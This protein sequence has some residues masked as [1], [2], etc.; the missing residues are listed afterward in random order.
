MFWRI[1][2]PT[3]DVKTFKNYFKL[4]EIH[5]M[6]D[7]LFFGVISLWT[8]LL[9]QWCEIVCI[10][11]IK[12]HQS[13]QLKPWNLP[14]IR[15]CS[16]FYNVVKL[17]RICFW[18]CLRIFI[19]R[20]CENR[21]LLS[22][23]LHGFKPFLVLAIP[24]AQSASTLSFVTKQRNCGYQRHSNVKPEQ[25]LIPWPHVRKN[26]QGR[27]QKFARG[28]GEKTTFWKFHWTVAV[29]TF[30]GDR[31]FQC[32]IKKLVCYRCN[33]NGWN[34]IYRFP[35]G[36]GGAHRSSLSLSHWLQAGCG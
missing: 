36:G 12:I 35:A 25:V 10:W 17:L 7:R 6:S 22:R 24:P 32:C 9:L 33:P 18:S 11:H 34:D 13:K 21:F 28:G 20:S 3:A 5:S 29:K 2:N 31:Y 15:E 19:L 23:R 4:C 30:F 1:F 26:Y 14:F 8:K 27:T 16:D